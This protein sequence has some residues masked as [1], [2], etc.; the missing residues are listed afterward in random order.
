MFVTL[1]EAERKAKEKIRSGTFIWAVSG[2]EDDHTTNKNVLD[3]KKIQIYPRVLSNIQNDLDL[4]VEIFD[5]KFDLPLILSPMG[6]QTQFH[7]HGEI[8]MCKGTEKF[9]IPVSFTTQGRTPLDLIKKNT[10]Q[11]NLIWQFFLFG[12]KNWI[13]E[14]IR[15]AEKN[16]C[17]AISICL[18]APVR[19]YRYSD[20]ESGYDARKYGKR[21]LKLSP[22]PG[23]ALKYDFSIIKWI[24]S[25]T[26]LPIIPKGIMHIEDSKK[27]I[28]CGVDA[29]WISNHGGRMFN[30][31][32]SV[33][34]SLINHKKFLKKNKIP[35]IVDGGVR[36]GS[37]IMKYISLGADIVGVG[38][39][40]LYGLIS[41]G[42][43]GVNRIF[44]ILSEELKISMI[45][46]GYKNLKLLKQQ[47]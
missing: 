44:E 45:N 27:L 24:K 14:Q 8:E 7:K 11:K 9:N 28:D 26:K 36:G 13:L 39:P 19:S 31:G 21:F 15:I 18:D 34:D 25:K 22:E 41:Y 4:S 12:D 37:D 43:K 35:I 1:R 33:V 42:Q 30:S 2:A 10:N 47:L 38:R 3:L 40:A 29:I 6:H 23:M 5:Q 16:D 32:V 20:R 46:S 17:I